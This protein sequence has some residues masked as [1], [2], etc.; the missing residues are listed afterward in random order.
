[1]AVAGSNLAGVT[2]AENWLKSTG[3]PLFILSK[4]FVNIRID[5]KIELTLLVRILLFCL[6]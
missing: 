6:S 2:L 3:S 4:S 5:E 1:M